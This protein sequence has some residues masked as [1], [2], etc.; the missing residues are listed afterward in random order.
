MAFS[1]AAKSR[2]NFMARR[3]RTVDSMATCR[4][5]AIPRCF[6]FPHAPDVTKV[7]LNTDRCK[8]Q[9]PHR[10]LPGKRGNYG[11]EE[12]THPPERGCRVVPS[13][14]P[15]RLVPRDLQHNHILGTLC[16]LGG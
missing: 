12:N 11:A 2:R 10:K 5:W 8:L 6:A 3:L 16:C 15:H 7:F 4:L 1:T 14:R 9:R 13:R